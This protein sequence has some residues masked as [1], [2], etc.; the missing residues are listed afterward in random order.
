MEFM[1]DYENMS[2][3]ENDSRIEYFK[4]MHSYE[5]YRL[6]YYGYLHL[7]SHWGNVM[8]NPNYP[9]FTNDTTIINS[10]ILTSYNTAYTS[11]ILPSWKS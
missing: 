3:F 10:N 2:E 11:N 1:D 4:V 9:Y 5:L 7:D 6:G 8:I